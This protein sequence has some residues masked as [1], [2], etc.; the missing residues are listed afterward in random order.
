[1]N[2]M[3]HNECE[4]EMGFVPEIGVADAITR[5][6]ALEQQLR[7]AK[8]QELLALNFAASA[9][10]T[11]LQ[12][13]RDICQLQEDLLYELSCKQSLQQEVLE[14]TRIIAD[15]QE[16]LIMAG[17]ASWPVPSGGHHPCPTSHVVR[18][19]LEAKKQ[20]QSVNNVAHISSLSMSLPATWCHS[21]QAVTKPPSRQQPQRKG[22]TFDVSPPLA[23]R[24]DPVEPRRSW[25][26]QLKQPRA[27][28]CSP[29]LA[30]RMVPCTPRWTS[31]S[32]TVLSRS[33]AVDS[34]S[35]TCSDDILDDIVLRTSVDTT[36]NMTFVNSQST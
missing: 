33:T 1:M 27:I 31:H 34:S 5:I 25:S 14:K 4:Q 12:K 24:M 7:E 3:P 36:Q 11:L 13:D 15:L 16:Q 35:S 17:S 26:L 9:G 8:K 6:T 18:N 30:K 10:S 19:P 2:Q 22:N 28:D 29:P 21:D 32:P 20:D 23:K